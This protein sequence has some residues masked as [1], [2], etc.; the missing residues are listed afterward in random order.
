MVMK[1]SQAQY[2]TSAVDKS[3]LIDDGRAQFAFVG[4]SNVGKS[5][6]INRLVGQKRLAKTSSTPGLTKMVNYFLVNNQF[7]FVDLPGYGFAKTNHANKKSWASVIEQY[8]TFNQNLRVVFVLLDLRH[9]PTQLDKDMIEFLL[10]HAIP[11]KII[12][13]K[14]DKLAK[15]KIPQACSAMAKQ[16]GI[17]PQLI[18]PL[19]SESGY[20]I[21]KLLEFIGG[22]LEAGL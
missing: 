5:S 18:S 8:L 2:V 3:S 6:L 1:I 22:N 7:Y 17:R 20:G 19:S 15:S 12:A 9:S 21:D 4:R 10:F 11:F 16:L 14:A 13:T